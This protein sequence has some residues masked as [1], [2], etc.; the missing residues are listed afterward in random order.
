[1]KQTLKLAVNLSIG[2]L[3]VVSFPLQNSLNIF[4]EKRNVV[5]T[6]VA[7]FAFICIGENKI[8]FSHNITGNVV[9]NYKRSLLEWGEINQMTTRLDTL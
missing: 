4:P 6:V 5:L 9:T 3:W 1:M 2:V 8:A 7:I